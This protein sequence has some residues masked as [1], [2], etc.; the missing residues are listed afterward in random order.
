M[1]LT[2]VVSVINSFGSR[3][4][5]PQAGITDPAPVPDLD[6]EAKLITDPPESGYGSYLDIFVAIGK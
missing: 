3:S 5:D 1:I 4:A 6:P 2:S